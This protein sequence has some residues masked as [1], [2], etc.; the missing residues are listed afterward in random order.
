MSRTEKALQVL[1]D[2]QRKTLDYKSKSLATVPNESQ[3]DRVK[4][5]ISGYLQALYEIGALTDTERKLLHI[6]Y[7]D[8]H[9]ITI[10]HKER[11][12]D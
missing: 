12:T 1:T 10:G 2:R 4:G 5:S 7:T 8:T 3:R 9:L 6:Y 11:T